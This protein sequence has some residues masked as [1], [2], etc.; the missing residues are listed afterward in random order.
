MVH[1]IQV[2]NAVILA[3]GYGKRMKQKKYF[4]SKPMTMVGKKPLISYA[5]DMLIDGGIEKIYI[6]YH[7]VTADVLKLLNYS[8]DYVKYLE[9][10]EEDIQ[11]GTL[12][13]FS[14]IKNFI[15]PPFIM[16]FEDIIA[17]KSDFVN[18][19][20]VGKKYITSDTDLII[21][22]VC[23][24]SVLSEKAF[25]TEKGRIIEYRKNGI[26]GEVKCNQRKKYG[27]MVYL[28]NSDPFQIIDRYLMNQNYKFS[29][30][31]ENYVLNHTVYEMPI[32][33][34][35]DIDTPEAVKLTEELLKRW[36]DWNGGI[37]Q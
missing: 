34:M 4:S 16:V 12:L 11:K 33:D 10:I 13:S 36:G 23:A 28:W 25:L 22:T 30:F 20:S 1:D 19:L 17:R 2:R 27:G 3:S 5:I 15:S 21:Q 32:N 31:L 37:K 9:F 35:W 14:R 8:N 6:I 7:S 18:M 29:F 26:T 24:P